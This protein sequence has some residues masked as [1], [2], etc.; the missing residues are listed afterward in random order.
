MVLKLSIYVH[1][2]FHHT[3]FLKEKLTDG[4]WEKDN[5]AFIHLAM[6][7]KPLYLDL[8]FQLLF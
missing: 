1:P 8:I 5:G 6:Q 7:Q 4:V 2:H 3:Q